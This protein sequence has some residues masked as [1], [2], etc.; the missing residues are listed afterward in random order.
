MGRFLRE[1]GVEAENAFSAVL[2]ALQVLD[3]KYWLR[4]QFD[5]LHG[6]NYHGMGEI[7]F[8]GDDKAYR[9][10]WLLRSASTAL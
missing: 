8:D 9:G 2:G 10:I 6:E 1:L 5:V 3:R 4:P 7:R